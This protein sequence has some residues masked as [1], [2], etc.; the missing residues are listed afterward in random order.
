MG[1]EPTKKKH[2]VG[3]IPLTKKITEGDEPTKKK[4][5]VG[6]IPLTKKLQW[7]MNPLTKN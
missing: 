3:E 5:T 7:E 2:T 1:D 4:H 6:E